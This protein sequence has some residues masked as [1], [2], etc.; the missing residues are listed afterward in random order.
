MAHLKTHGTTK[1]AA[2]AKRLGRTAGSVASHG[3]LLW[4]KVSLGVVKSGAFSNSE[5]AVLR[6]LHTKYGNNWAAI[7]AT[8]ELP[9]RP[10]K[11]IQRAWETI[12]GP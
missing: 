8:G 3:R 4:S 11:Q 10:R 9:G 7:F 2:L 5:M 1:W 6:S 12:A